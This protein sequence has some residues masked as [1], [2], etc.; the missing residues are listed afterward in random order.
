MSKNTVRRKAVH[1]NEV[2]PSRKSF[3]IIDPLAK[4]VNQKL[5][6]NERLS[7]DTIRK[8]IW[9]FFLTFVYIFLQHRFDGMIRK[10]DNT[11]KQL[12]EARASYISYKSKY[13]FASK[14]SELIKQLET[15]G[16]EK[17]GVPPFKIA[18]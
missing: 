8:S 11:E 16:F 1:S 6:I 5:D 9:F 15:R 7:T 13:L 10:L 4:W 3:N 17:N 12:Q 14:Q 18:K 2:P